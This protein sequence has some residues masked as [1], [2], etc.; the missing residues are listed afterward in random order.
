MK[1]F[2]AIPLLFVALG[3]CN[4]STVPIYNTLD[5]PTTGYAYNV[6]FP[7]NQ[8]FTVTSDAMISNITVGIPSKITPGRQLNVGFYDLNFNLLKQYS[9][10][11]SYYVNVEHFYSYDGQLFNLPVGEYYLRIKMSNGP[12]GW[13]ITSGGMLGRIDAYCVPETRYM[14]IIAGLV[15]AGILFYKWKPQDNNMTEL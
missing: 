5:K 11:D 9:T 6:H 14:S 12:T 10:P 7:I 8:K 4:A 2:A 3:T 13:V 1:I 15:L